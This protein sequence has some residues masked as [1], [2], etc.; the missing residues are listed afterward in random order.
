[1]ADVTMCASWACPRRATCARTEESGVF[2][3]DPRRQ[4]YASFGSGDPAACA[5][6]VDASKVTARA[7]RELA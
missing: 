7:K 1:M 2:T 5:Y 4:S 6:F 3:P